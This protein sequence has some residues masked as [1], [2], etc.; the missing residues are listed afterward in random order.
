[1][2]H[3]PGQLGTLFGTSLGQVRLNI[4]NQQE[5]P[6][7]VPYIYLINQESRIKKQDTRTIE[8]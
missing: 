1:M 6:A 7:A 8:S 3:C 5:Y 4:N 2:G